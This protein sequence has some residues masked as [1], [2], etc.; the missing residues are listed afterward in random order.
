VRDF[1]VLLVAGAL[2]GAGFGA[3]PPF[4]R[5]LPLMWG[6]LG[7][8]FAFGAFALTS[9]G[10]AQVWGRP[11]G[12]AFGGPTGLAPGGATWFA[13]MA[14]PRDAVL[15]AWVGAAAGLFAGAI[16]GAYLG[17]VAFRQEFRAGRYE[18]RPEELQLT[19]VT[20][21]LETAFGI[22]VPAIIL[23]SQRRA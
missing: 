13:L 7:G 9:E 15:W 16:A 17:T 2:I 1:A 23:F 3:C 8:M 21:L 6:A 20:L 10:L 5:D 18:R 12:W 4:R 22:G 19:V 14:D 11:L